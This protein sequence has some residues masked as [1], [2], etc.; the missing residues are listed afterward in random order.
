MTSLA[1]IPVPA[2]AANP[3]SDGQSLGQAANDPTA[4]LMAIQIQDSYNG[5]FHQLKDE[6]ANTVILRPV[7]PFKLG[8]VKNIARATI[9]YITDSPTGKTGL[10]DSV[11]FDLIVFDKPWGRWGVGPV[12]LLPTASEDELGAEK[13][14]LGPALGFVAREKKFMWGL[15]NQNLITVAGDDDREDV[16]LSILQPIVNVSLPNK[17]S[18]GVSEMNATYDWNLNDWTNLPLGVKLSKLVKLGDQPVQFSG[19]YEYNFQDD[20]IAPE[21]TVNFTVKLLFP[22]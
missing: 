20:Y 2:L 8:G 19:Y 1:T 21:W 9:P 7:I 22:I 4:S 16:N 14:A 12:A 11:L 3:D 6:E 13:W 10:G 18:I 5:N 15:F 17:W